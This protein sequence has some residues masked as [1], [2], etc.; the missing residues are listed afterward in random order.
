[1]PRA[2]WRTFHPGPP[3]EGEATQRRTQS[4]HSSFVSGTRAQGPSARSAD[5]GRTGSRPRRQPAPRTPSGFEHPPPDSGGL[6]RRCA[7]HGQRGHRQ[8]SHQPAGNSGG[9]IGMRRKR[10]HLSVPA[11]G[12][13]LR[14][15][16]R[17]LL[18]PPH[19]GPCLRSVRKPEA[20]KMPVVELRYC[21]QP[22]ARLVSISVPTP[23]KG[24]W[25]EG[26]PVP[27]NQRP[28]SPRPWGSSASTNG[29]AGSRRR[30]LRRL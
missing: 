18:A 11:P 1:M 24:R 4:A 20:S 5:S 16:T 3:L 12:R 14:C 23:G 22:A 29:D 13:R 17:P 10:A 6:D 30:R 9:A 21:R 27:A 19:P 7:P 8:L 15:N 26:V 25:C 2:P 28:V